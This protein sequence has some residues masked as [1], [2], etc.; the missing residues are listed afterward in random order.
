MARAR[1]IAQARFAEA[2]C[3]IDDV[4]GVAG[5]SELL[6]DSQTARRAPKRGCVSSPSG[7]STIAS[8]MRLMTGRTS[9]PMIKH[10]QSIRRGGAPTVWCIAPARL[11]MS[12]S[13]T[14]F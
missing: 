3:E 14:P 8:T 13:T 10:W 12:F 4:D 1:R 2:Q 7:S 9:G 11:T 6:I 5:D